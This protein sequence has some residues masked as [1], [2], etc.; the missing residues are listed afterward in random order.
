MQKE[1]FTGKGI[2]S[3]EK[4]TYTG[5][6]EGNLKHGEGVYESAKERYTGQYSKG[7]KNGRG[8]IEFLD[9]GDSYT[10]TFVNG[11]IQGEG[12]FKWRTGDVYTGTFE[13]NKMRGRGF[14]RWKNGDVYEG[15]YLNNVK[16]GNGL[17]KWKRT[18]KTYQG[19]FINNE[20]VGKLQ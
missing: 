9:K 19:L 18:G 12:E 1:N 4:H 7:K 16:S 17:M 15:E 8:T 11:A 10:G 3:S 2:E 5:D 20:P 13:V 6:F 14:Y